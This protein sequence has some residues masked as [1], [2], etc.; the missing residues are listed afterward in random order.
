MLWSL[1][2]IAEIIREQGYDACICG[3]IHDSIVMDVHHDC[4][5]DVIRMAANVM[6]EQLEK[7]MYWVQVPMEVEPDVAPMGESWLNA[8]KYKL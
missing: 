4:L 5:D 7:E 6:T 8:T 1:D 2:H 3:Q